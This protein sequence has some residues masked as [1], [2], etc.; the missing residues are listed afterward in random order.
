MMLVRVE[1]GH[2]VLSAMSSYQNLNVEQHFFVAFA[3]CVV[4]YY[5]LSG[6][7]NNM[8][9]ELCEAFQTHMGT[10]N[11]QKLEKCQSQIIKIMALSHMLVCG[12]H[13]FA[14]F[15]TLRECAIFRKLVLLA[16]IC[17]QSSSQRIAA[18]SFFCRLTLE[19]MFSDLTFTVHRSIDYRTWSHGTRLETD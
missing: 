19:S 10:Q 14:M 3:Q 12:S 11:V 4:I 8:C 18:K 13:T 15:H 6:R 17:Q 2:T 16:C 7:K 9:F 1:A 5:T